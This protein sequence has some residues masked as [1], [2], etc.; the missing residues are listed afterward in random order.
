MFIRF[1]QKFSWK[2]NNFHFNQDETCMYQIKKNIFSKYIFGAI[3]KKKESLF[4]H[5][6][7]NYIVDNVDESFF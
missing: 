7:S 2:K 6:E 3:Y 5:M 4:N 1:Q